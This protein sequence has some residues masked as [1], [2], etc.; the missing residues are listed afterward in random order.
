MLSE[1]RKRE[2]LSFLDIN[3]KN[4][5]EYISDSHKLE[6]S[7]VGCAAKSLILVRE[8]LENVKIVQEFLEE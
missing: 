4:I 5:I 7:L 2:Y 1:E 8:Y 6:K 3:E